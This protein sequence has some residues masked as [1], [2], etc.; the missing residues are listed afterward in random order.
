MQSR[1][2]NISVRLAAEE[3]D[4]RERHFT[5]H[6]KHPT[7]LNKTTRACRRS[8]LF[9]VKERARSCLQAG[10]A[11]RQWWPAGGEKEREGSRTVTSAGMMVEDEFT[12]A[13]SS[14]YSG[15][16]GASCFRFSGQA[17]GACAPADR[18]RLG[19]RRNGALTV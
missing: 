16:R 18:R 17:K 10:Y 6:P 13:A 19:V 4:G 15:T 5:Q 3:V 2:H 11:V 8:R 1:P 9:G 12:L 7:S 14:K